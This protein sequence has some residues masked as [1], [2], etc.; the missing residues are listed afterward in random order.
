MKNNTF[1]IIGG[2]VAGLAS[3]IAVANS[4]NTAIVMEKAS[5]FE[6][7]G[8]GLQL[9]PNAVRA[10]QKLGAWDAVAPIV[11]SPPE[12]HIRNGLDGKTLSRI[13]LGQTF[14]QRFGMPYRTAHRADLV[15]ALLTVARTKS[16]I[17]IL[18]ATEVF[19]L[20]PG[21]N[22]IAADGLWSKS[23]ESL[24]PN[25]KAVLTGEK[26][27]R[28]L[29]DNP[30]T[31]NITIWLYPGGH[32]VHYPV[33]H[34]EKLNLV[35]I[36]QG[37]D[38]GEHYAKACDELKDV[39]AVSKSW[40]E[41]F[42]AYVPPIPKWNS[43]NITLIGDAAHGTLPYLAQGAAMA[44]EDSAA[45]LDILN[46]SSG[47]VALDFQKLSEIRNVRTKQLHLASVRSG[48]I[49]HLAGMVA[50][51]RNIT[52]SSMPEFVLAHQLNWIYKN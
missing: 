17:Q 8:A 9:G 5:K 39:L 12:I 6:A 35:A 4:G 24:F 42:A 47:D 37:H 50:T 32:V 1:Q 27:F 18:T 36:T 13:N 51:L 25:S 23:R 43:A 28:T 3:A 48:R 40:T 10:L 46:Q 45:L 11:N 14:E 29:I 2:G 44:L 49:Y 21:K 30:Q 19:A 22:I 34:P 16:T 41:W 20:T 31:K 7:A 26:Y 52:L 38:V 15:N 33:G